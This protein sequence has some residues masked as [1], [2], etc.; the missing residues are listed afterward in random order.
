MTKI[1]MSKRQMMVEAHKMA[2]K[3]FGDY[4]ARLA[5]ALRTLWAI[6]KKG[7]KTMKTYAWSTAKGADVEL[8]VSA[9]AKIEKLIINGTEHNSMF[10][11]HK[12]VH[13]LQLT[14]NSK[15]ALVPVP[16]NMYSEIM[17]VKDEMFA[18]SVKAEQR[19]QRHYDSVKEAMSY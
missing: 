1:K 2:R 3:M 8:T 18:K 17:A 4:V 10:T 12:G 11:T 5:L 19:Y 14:L 15:Q 9:D 7:A 13:Y 6:A 16:E